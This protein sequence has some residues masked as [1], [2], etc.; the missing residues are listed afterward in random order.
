[1][2]LLYFADHVMPLTLNCKIMRWSY[3]VECAVFY[4][5]A[6]KTI[7]SYQEHHSSSCSSWETRVNHYKL[8]WICTTTACDEHTMFIVNLSSITFLIQRLRKPKYT[9]ETSFYQS[10]LLWSQSL[11]T[12]GQVTLNYKLMRWSYEVDHNLLISTTQTNLSILDLDLL[13]IL[14]R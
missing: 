12:T 7:N 2:R 13:F 1:M 9:P 11:T 4:L 14:H 8:E 6:P 3:N 10:W 5:A